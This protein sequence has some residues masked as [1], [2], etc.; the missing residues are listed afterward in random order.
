M[1]PRFMERLS[2][3]LGRFFAPYDDV[4]DLVAI[5]FYGLG[6][7][8]HSHHLSVAVAGRTRFTRGFPEG[9]VSLDVK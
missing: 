8:Q 4:K 1:A 6:P 3:C 2:D 9:E 7:P 5:G